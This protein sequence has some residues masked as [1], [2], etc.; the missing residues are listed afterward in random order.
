MMPA[1]PPPPGLPSG[2]VG[3]RRRRAAPPHRHPLGVLWAALALLALGWVAL[4]SV[5]T[6][7]AGNW[8]WHLAEGLLLGG[9]MNLAVLPWLAVA[10]AAAVAEP[11]LGAAAAPRRRA[12]GLPLALG[13]AG[14]LLALVGSHGLVAWLAAGL[15]LSAAGL[16][17]VA[18]RWVVA[19]LDSAG[20]RTGPHGTWIGMGLA[21]LALCVWAAAVALALDALP[22]VRA[23]MVLSCWVGT[24]GLVMV[25]L[26]RVLPGFGQARVPMAPVGQ[27]ISALRLCLCA[28]LLHGGLAAAEAWRGPALLGW[29]S[30]VRSGLD[31]G[32]GV[33]LMALALAGGLRLGF[34]PRVAAWDAQGQPVWLKPSALRL[35]ALPQWALAWLGVAL[36]LAGWAQVAGGFGFPMTEAGTLLA[37][38][39]GQALHVGAM[40]SGL[41]A[42]ATWHA[43]GRA[44]ASARRGLS[45]WSWAA[46]LAWQAGSACLVLAALFPAAR[47]GWMVLGLQALLLAAL[48]WWALHGR[49]G[50]PAGPGLSPPAG[51]W[52]R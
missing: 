7:L 46:A 20:R 19:L 36:V 11:A 4:S 35:M 39:A 43:L 9:V 47:L 31:I 38:G 5:E 16:A 33:A 45:P 12:Y 37:Q 29:S 18:G 24:G 13:L 27:G 14:A 22:V 17:L 25:A 50:R 23:C 42:L 44:P 6:V 49:P 32:S 26:H 51:P 41:W 3:L 30:S 10:A 52:S 21:L 48:T 2:T 1:A 34:V 8:R 15:A 28:L 40:G